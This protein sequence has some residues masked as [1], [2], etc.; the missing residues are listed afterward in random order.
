MTDAPW[1][2]VSYRITRKR[3]VNAGICASHIERSVPSELERTTTRA[4]AGPSTRQWKRSPRTSTIGSAII[5]ST[6]PGER[7]VDQLL[8]QTEIVARI[9]QARD[10][11]R[12]QMRRDARIRRE[13][14]T[15]R[16]ARGNR[17]RGGFLHDGMRDRLAELFSQLCRDRFGE[18]RLGCSRVSEP[19]LSFYVDGCRQELHADVPQGPW[20]F[21]FSLTRWDERPFEGGETRRSQRPEL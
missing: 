15:E 3:P 9:E 4:S 11:S 5:V 20:A 17:L 19:W 8:R 2:R 1:P 13:N 21:V 16:S 6:P 7:T 14:V 18:D 10:L 12:R